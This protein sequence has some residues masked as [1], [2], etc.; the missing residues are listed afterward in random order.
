MKQSQKIL[1]GFDT[2]VKQMK[3]GTVPVNCAQEALRDMAGTVSQYPVNSNI[4]HA[5]ARLMGEAVYML[6]RANLRIP[7]IS[8]YITV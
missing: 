2:Y 7:D 4:R 3:N 5:Y 1:L 8:R 6:V